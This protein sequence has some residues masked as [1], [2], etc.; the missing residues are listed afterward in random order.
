M[1]IQ[2]FSNK[3]PDIHSEETKNKILKYLNSNIPKSNAN[4]EQLY[5]MS[6]LEI[7][8]DNDYIVC[9]KINGVRSW[10]IFFREDEKYYAVSFPKHSQKKRDSIRIFSIDVSVEKTYYRGTIMEGIYYREGNKKYLIIDE[11]Y[12]LFGKDQLIK[13]KGERLDSMSSIIKTSINNSEFYS[14]CVGKYYEIN[15]NSLLCLFQEIKSD[16]NIRDIIFYPK[17]Y[18]GKI[19]NYTIVISDL[20]DDVVKTEYFYLEKTNNPDVYNILL[21]KSGNN[22]KIDI[23]YIPNMETSKKCKSWFKNS[24]KKILFVKCQMDFKKNKW[25]PIELA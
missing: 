19:Y 6:Q 3:N 24:K 13:S 4:Y 8:K 2:T 14:I 10:I 5:D 21:N 11:I 18:G 1:N 25:I 16:Q 9:P 23:A 12:K 17:M 20:T 15:K 22:E 7:I